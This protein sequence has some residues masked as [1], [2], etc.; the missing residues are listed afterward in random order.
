MSLFGVALLHGLRLAPFGLAA[1]DQLQRSPVVD[2]RDALLAEDLEALLGEAFVA[3]GKIVHG[4]HGS[5]VE[6]DGQ[7]DHVGG[8]QARAPGIQPGG[9]KVH[10]L[11]PGDRL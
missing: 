5:V 10:R 3:V 9:V 2:H 6:A 8:S 4:A 11:C 1:S 7:G